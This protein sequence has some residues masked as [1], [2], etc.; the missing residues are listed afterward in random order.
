MQEGGLAVE[1]NGEQFFIKGLDNADLK[2][3]DDTVTGK[4]WAKYQH[5][6]PVVRIL[7]QISN[8]SL[9]KGENHTYFNLLYS[10][11]S[12]SDLDLKMAQVSN[13]AVLVRGD[14][15]IVFAV[16]ATQTSSRAS[17]VASRLLLLSSRSRPLDTPLS[18]GPPLNGVRLALGASA[19]FPSSLI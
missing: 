15:D 8:V 9:R 11:D 5:A 4:N 19:L 2:L 6:E 1:Q 3:E 14:D 17:E 18:M 7:Q 10:P 16:S 13:G 12:G